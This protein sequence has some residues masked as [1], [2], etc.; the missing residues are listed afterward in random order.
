L[1]LRRPKK[2]SRPPQENRTA[3]ATFTSYLKEE[4]TMADDKMES[5]NT[6]P[7]AD[8][9]AHTEIAEREGKEGAQARKINKEEA[10]KRKDS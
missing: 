9:Q 5:E 3:R 4:R 7:Q 2:E 8:K 6:V 1:G 10:D